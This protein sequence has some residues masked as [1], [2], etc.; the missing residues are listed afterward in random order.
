MMG[1]P[2]HGLDEVLYA[3]GMMGGAGQELD[4]TKLLHQEFYVVISQ[5]RDPHDNAK[6]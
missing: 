3:G 6:K 2:G 1:G 5:M 4:T